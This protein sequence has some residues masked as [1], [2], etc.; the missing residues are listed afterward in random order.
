MGRDPLSS[1]KKG[2]ILLVTF[3]CAVFLVVDGEKK[4]RAPKQ[5]PFLPLQPL[6]YPGSAPNP[7]F[8]LPSTFS[9]GKHGVQD[10]PSVGPLVGARI[11][12]AP[13]PLNEERV[14]SNLLRVGTSL[15]RQIGTCNELE[16]EIN[17]ERA[18]NGLG[19]LKCDHNMRW[20]ANK[21][22]ENQLDNGYT[23]GKEFPNGCN[24]H[25][26][27]GDIGCCFST[28]EATWPCMW[29]KPLELS[30]WDDRNGY[31][32]SVWNSATITPSGAVDSWRGSSA[33]HNVILTQGDWTDLKTVGCGWR[34]TVAHCWFAKTEP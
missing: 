31:E 2:S 21:H 29:N 3:L 18:R 4:D 6:I 5:L 23:D 26:W 15:A 30:K 1:K 24:G 16:T 25:S 27:L 7:Y 34:K 22:V 10:L 13:P 33:H 8:L 20:V 9:S 12:S 32:I 19:P 14:E 28:H 11:G 17:K